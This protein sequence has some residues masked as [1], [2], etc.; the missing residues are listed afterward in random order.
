VA[1]EEPQAIRPRRIAIPGDLN[2]RMNERLSSRRSGWRSGSG[3]GGLWCAVL[4]RRFRKSRVE[5]AGAAAGF[6]F[7]AYCLEGSSTEIKID[8]RE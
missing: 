4:D 5:R 1:G 8:D 2:R 7:K 6:D 3:A